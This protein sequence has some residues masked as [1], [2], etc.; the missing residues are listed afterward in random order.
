MPE[1]LS[2]RDIDERLWERRERFVSLWADLR[3]M[4]Y[5][6]EQDRIEIPVETLSAGQGSADETIEAITALTR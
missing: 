3:R 2:A 5:L 4:R 6:E 1:R